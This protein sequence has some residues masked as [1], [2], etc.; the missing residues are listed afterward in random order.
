MVYYQKEIELLIVIT[1][2]CNR[3]K[4]WHLQKLFSTFI[5][6]LIHSLGINDPIRM[7][8]EQESIK[9]ENV[10]LVCRHLGQCLQNY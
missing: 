6:K 1:H 5:Q 2:I 8:M 3:G 4:S 9:R 10:I 7:K